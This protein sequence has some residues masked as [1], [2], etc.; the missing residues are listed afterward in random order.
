[1]QPALVVFFMHS[2]ASAKES[3]RL[4]GIARQIKCPAIVDYSPICAELVHGPF[5]ASTISDLRTDIWWGTNPVMSGELGYIEMAKQGWVVILRRW[6][7]N[8][9][10]NVFSTIETIDITV[11]TV[12]VIQLLVSCSRFSSDLVETFRSPRII[13][14]LIIFC[15]ESNRVWINGSR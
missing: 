2:A 15:G 12:G 6:F 13:V 11:D 3:K 8:D 4:I 9:N 10:N 5:C 1:M 14:F 7:I